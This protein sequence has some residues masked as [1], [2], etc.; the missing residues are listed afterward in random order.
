MPQVTLSVSDKKLP[1]L[2]DM[3]KNMGIEAFDER[4]AISKH[5][6]VS[7]VAETFSHNANVETD[8]YFSWDCYSSE[9]E[10][11]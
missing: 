7:D 10:F 9:L 1:M 8:K 2:K 3:L 5:S 11:E 4:K 6:L